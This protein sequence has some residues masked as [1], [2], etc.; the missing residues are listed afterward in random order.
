MSNSKEESERKTYNG[1]ECWGIWE[2]S[3]EGYWSL[4]SKEWERQQRKNKS[5]SAVRAIR[6]RVRIRVTVKS[7]VKARAYIRIVYE[8]IKPRL[9]RDASWSGAGWHFV[10]LHTVIGHQGTDIL[11]YA[12]KLQSQAWNRSEDWERRRQVEEKNRAH[13]LHPGSKVEWHLGAQSLTLRH[14]IDQGHRQTAWA[15]Q[16]CSVSIWR[17]RTRQSKQ[18][19]RERINEA[20]NKQ[21]QRQN[22]DIQIPKLSWPVKLWAITHLVAIPL[23]IES[24]TIRLIRCKFRISKE[25]SKCN[26]WTEQNRWTASK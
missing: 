22:T 7:A 14:G 19:E 16:W 13:K 24:T 2:S 12:L 9:L 6:K 3:F 26:F 23:S 11:L 10:L 25:Q 5:D 20:I 15:M 8:S 1:I 17:L 18:K 4:E 21:M